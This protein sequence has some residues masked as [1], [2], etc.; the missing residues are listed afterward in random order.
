MK[1]H[2]EI[3]PAFE[4]AL[5]SA[6][7][8]D[9]DAFMR[10]AGGRP[11]SKHRHRETL[12]IEIEI[13]GNPHRFFLKRVFKVPMKHTLWPKLRGEQGQSQP[14][15]EWRRCCDLTR[16]GIP[17][18]RAVAYGQRCRLGLPV[19]AFL[20]VEA[21]PMSHT[22]EN[23]LVPG[24]PK[25][26]P[27][28]KAQRD[29]LF[30]ELGALIGR[31]GEAGFTWPDI[32]AKHIFTERSG[33]ASS[34][35]SWR[36][37][38]IDVERMER[39]ASN[40]K[41]A[42]P[43]RRGGLL[44]KL[45]RSLAPTCLSLDD[46]LRLWSG[47][48]LSGEKRWARCEDERTLNDPPLP[49]SLAA[50]A[51]VPMPRL[52]DD[53]EHPRCVPLRKLGRILA[54]QRVIPWLEAAGI[55]G[56]KDVFRYDSGD[57]IRKAGLSPHR[58]R[59]RMVLRNEKGEVRTFYLKRYRKPPL[60][61]QLRRIRECGLRSSR[62]WREMHFIKRLSLLGIPTLRGV[63]FGQKMK[64]PLEK[65]SF[66]ISE[67]IKGCSLE[68][69]AEQ[70]LADGSAVP[71]WTNRR[72]IIHQLAL[73]TARLHRHGLF[74]RDLYL[75]HVFVCRNADGRI[76]LRLIDL[77][78]MIEKKRHNQRWKTKDLASL[79][80]S[81]PPLLVTRADRLRFL[82]DYFYAMK[83]HAQD[84]SERRRTARDWIKRIRARVR[85]TG[86]HEAR[87]ARP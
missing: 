37:C 47:S 76:V 4:S 31:L 64:G 61:E 19:Q 8:Q 12:P 27:L 66:A 81:A 29:R 83:G 17:V 60:I 59:M 28:E 41:R 22:L 30:Q 53:Y 69:R 68:K 62:A 34:D 15:I 71:S 20:L 77:A 67:E 35:R 10:L 87:R 23:W 24:F 38:L 72:D 85:R 2:L 9:F 46:L 33:T 13:D 43:A 21:V 51:A 44:L 5:C 54:D 16:A 11:T 3:D 18:M 36:F 58:D 50:L 7:L 79:D 75:C 73:I 42:D 70:A 82:Y 55:R 39:C 1:T 78:R 80:Y 25:P 49:E 52:P 48:L 57:A 6:G 26:A 14:A 56:F 32:C 45:C 65:C 40:S 74:H 63:A 86:R 84:R